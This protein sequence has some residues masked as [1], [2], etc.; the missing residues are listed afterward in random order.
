MAFSSSLRTGISRPFLSLPSVLP[1]IWSSAPLVTVRG[2]I[3]SLVRALV[4]RVDLWVPF[5]CTLSPAG[6]SQ[7]GGNQMLPEDA[8]VS[9]C[10][11]GPPASQ[12]PCGA[13]PVPAQEVV[14]L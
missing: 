5:K 8:Q 12:Q 4:M 9:A 7:P 3:Q 10:G 14:G 1:H 2:L 11:T 6:L 13:G